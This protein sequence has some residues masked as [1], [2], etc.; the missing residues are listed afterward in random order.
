M[1]SRRQ[2]LL[3]RVNWC[4]QSSINTLL[5]KSQV[6]NFIIEVVVTDRFHYSHLIFA[7]HIILRDMS[8]NI[9]CRIS[10]AAK[11]I[12]DTK[13][14]KEHQSMSLP[15]HILRSM[16]VKRFGKCSKWQHIIT[17]T[18]NMNTLRLEQNSL[19]FTDDG[20]K[21]A[22]LNG[23]AY[24]LTKIWLIVFPTF[25][26]TINQHWFRFGAKPL[27]ESILANIYHASMFINP[28]WI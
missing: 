4:L 20:V 11:C 2:K 23:N 26:F 24:I 27:P 6:T 8:V 1:S 12:I 21:F 22:L 16:C 19:H 17:H 13:W 9:C 15:L 25:Q 5:N 28:Q 10:R 14:E 3:A 7:A 18:H